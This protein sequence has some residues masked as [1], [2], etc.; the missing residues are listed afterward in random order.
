ML[1]SNERTLQW[2]VLE[3]QSI[4]WLISNPADLGAVRMVIEVCEYRL[5]VSIDHSSPYNTLH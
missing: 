1:L 4:F 5:S 3:V 2:R